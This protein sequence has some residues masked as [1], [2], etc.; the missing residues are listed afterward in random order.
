MAETWPV[1]A[2]SFSQKR[3]WAPIEIFVSRVAATATGMSVNGGAKTMSQSWTP[4]TSGLKAAKKARVSA[5]VLNIFQLPAIRRR[6]IERSPENSRL[7]LSR[8]FIRQRFD[9]GQFRSTKE[10][11]RSAA[12][13]GNV[14]DAR[15]NAGL[16]SGS[17]RIA[18]ADDGRGAGIG[19]SRDGLGD[20]ERAFG[21]SGHFKDAHRTVPDNGFGAGNFGAIRRDGF[22]ADVQTHL[23]GGNCG[24]IVN[25]GG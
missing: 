22:R 1:K 21:K 12:A 3:S 4:A 9:A 17:D 15:G 8:S 7:K 25:G 2:P 16:V 18:S 11:E 5:C 20:F 14:R 23:V 6:R 19:C 13:G 10:F 24:G